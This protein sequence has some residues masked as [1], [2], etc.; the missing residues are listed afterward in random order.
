MG[1]YQIRATTIVPV[2]VVEM[3]GGQTV[4]TDEIV[5]LP[6][7][8]GDH[9]VAEKLARRLTDDEI[10]ALLVDDGGGKGGGDDDDVAVR[11]AAL[12]EVIESLGADDFTA[13]GLP[14]VRAINKH[15]DDGAVPV[16]SDERDA[17]WAE[18]QAT[19]DT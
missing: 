6:D 8:Y 3:P 15:L 1:A 11:R 16:T 2:T 5:E 12:I 13:A 17:V 4:V 18:M 14:D 10:S 9:L 19:K 7:E